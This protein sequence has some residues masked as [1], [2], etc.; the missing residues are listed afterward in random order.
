MK[1]LY[2]LPIL[3]AAL[4]SGAGGTFTLGEVQAAASEPMAESALDTNDQGILERLVE[5][6]DRRHRSYGDIILKLAEPLKLTDE[7]LG[8]ITRIHQDN[9][10]RVMALGKKLRAA[11]Q[12][13]HTLFLDPSKDEAAIRQAAKG[14]TETFE[15]LVDTALKS[16]RDIN[17]VLNEE[18]KSKLLTLKPA[19]DP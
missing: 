17:A 6:R 7:Q 3:V 5:A 2:F 1:I 10:Q 14:H 16:R 13:A 19:A 11:T 12:W 8:K 18:Q 9:Q 4:M 15:E